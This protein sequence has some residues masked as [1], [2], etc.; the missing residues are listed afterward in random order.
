MKKPKLHN[1]PLAWVEPQK[2][3]LS[4]I[5]LS[6]IQYIPP[7]KLQEN[8]LNAIFFK[9]EAADYFIKLRQDILERGIIVPLIAKKN[10][11]LLAGHNRLR[12]A[13]ELQ[14]PKIPLQYVL[15]DLP[16]QSEREFIIKDNLYRR[17]FSNSEWIYLYKQLYPDFDQSIF[18]ENRG[19]GKKWNK[20]ENSV[21]L[22][23]QKQQRLTAEK[24]AKDTGQKL[25]AVQKQLSKYKKSIQQP[26]IAQPSILS[27]SDKQFIVKI[28]KE[29]LSLEKVIL[30]AD[31]QTVEHLVPLV[32]SFY[33][34]IKKGGK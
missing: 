34:T 17:H 16:E 33:E 11:T 26:E 7:S 19:G 32:K 5:R 14:L 25:S 15:D 6:E 20:T 8:P 2:V 29:L 21:L 3:E 4:G 12:I 30:G 24:I 28:E 27:V 18:Q 10:D 9:E 1:N 31:I 13:K 23:E 22:T